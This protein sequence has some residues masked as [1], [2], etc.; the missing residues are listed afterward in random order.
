MTMTK[1]INKTQPVVLAFASGQDIKVHAAGCADL[2]KAATKREAHNGIHT[3]TFPI[4]TTERDVWIDFNEDFL[5]EGG[6]DAA[7]PL[8]FLPCCKPAG[9]VAD[10]D[11]SWDAQD[12]SEWVELS[13]DAAADMSEVFQAQ[14]EADAITAE[15][16]HVVA[17]KDDKKVRNA[18]MASALSLGATAKQI[19]DLLGIEARAV[20][21]AVA[22]H[23]AKAAA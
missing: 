6:A 3:Q 8:E 20:R 4:G 11:R 23:E 16:A 14:A 10:A 7:W 19:G 2:N 15:L 12:D 5:N 13:T 18:Y 9:L 1:P 17:Y 22:R 21:E